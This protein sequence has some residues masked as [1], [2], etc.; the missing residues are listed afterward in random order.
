MERHL[1]YVLRA[2]FG[3]AGVLMD[4]RDIH[5][6]VATLGWQTVTVDLN[7]LLEDILHQA[8]KKKFSFSTTQTGEG[9]FASDKRVALANLLRLSHIFYENAP[10]I[11]VFFYSELLADGGVHIYADVSSKPP[12]FTIEPV[13]EGSGEMQFVHR[14][15]VLDEGKGTYFTAI[16]DTR[17]VGVPGDLRCE[18]RG[19]VFF[20]GVRFERVWRFR[21][22][23]QVRL[24]QREL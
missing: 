3:D 2:N 7:T 1:S 8:D 20:R 13:S 10:K 24:V 14:L 18:V 6:Y 5:R 11:H 23:V 21:N 12:F 22:E 17:H 15:P 9:W 4:A 19:V 16:E